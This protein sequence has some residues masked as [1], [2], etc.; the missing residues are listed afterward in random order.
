MAE[1]IAT[2]VAT[3]DLAAIRHNA[4]QLMACARGAKF[5]GVVKADAYGHGAFRIAEALMSEGADWLGVATVREGVELRD[6]GL[7]CPILVM[8]AIQPSWAPVYSANDLT[9]TVTSMDVIKGLASLKA[10]RLPIDLH[11]KLDT[12]MGRLGIQPGEAASATAQLERIPWINLTGF[13]TH[14]AGADMD[15][16]SSARRQIEVFDKSLRDVDTQGRF[17]HIANTEAICRLPESYAGY[18]L[19]LV[20]AGVGLYGSPVRPDTRDALDSRQAM[21]LSGQV[22]Q[23]K[24]VD[25]GTPVSYGGRW[26]ASRKT[27]VA[28]LGIGY[29]DGYRRVLE[30]RAWVS[31]N[32]EECPVVGVVCMDMVMAAVDPDVAVS[33]GDRAILFGGE[34]PHVAEVAEWAQT[35]PY[36]IWTGIGRRVARR[37]V[38]AE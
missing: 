8:G 3:I 27:V 11:L 37:Y 28:T 5:L 24:T 26:K 20:R 22:V 18:P 12:G 1:E 7:T 25:T 38:D 14:L 19:S 2:A 31:I 17:L 34:G 10:P 13:L 32:G 30:G 16:L 36:E 23:V 6:E 35:I 4:R 9:A 29:A 33:L 15:D 21:T